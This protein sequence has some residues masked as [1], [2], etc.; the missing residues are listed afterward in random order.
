MIYCLYHFLF[1]SIHTPPNSTSHSLYLCFPVALR[2]LLPF[3]SSSPQPRSISILSSSFPL[4]FPS[5]LLHL[6]LPSMASPSYSQS[7]IPVCI[8][9]DNRSPFFFPSLLRTL[10]TISR[11]IEF[12]PENLR[13]SNRDYPS[14]QN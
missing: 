3:Y 12:L 9:T 10:R 5:S 1:L 2:D 13:F 6:H 8:P 4:L 11:N 7:Q 14:L